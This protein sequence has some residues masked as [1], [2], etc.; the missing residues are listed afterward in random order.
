[1][2]G[3]KI[4]DTYLGSYNTI[5]KHP[6]NQIISLCSGRN[7]FVDD[8]FM[9]VKTLTAYVFE[10][11]NRAIW[12]SQGNPCRVP[13]Y[14]YAPF[15]GS[16]GPLDVKYPPDHGYQYLGEIAKFMVDLFRSSIPYKNKRTIQNGPPL[17]GNW[18]ITKDVSVRGETIDM[19]GDIVVKSGATLNLHN[20]RLIMHSFTVGLKF[21]SY[22]RIVVEKGAT[23]KSLQEYH[24]EI[25]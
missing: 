25:K 22:N 8:M 13:Y 16:L 14:R 20:V 3:I 23:I 7:A 11:M 2:C 5:C 21:G 18:I 6:T 15:D 4:G 24:S 10:P 12:I 17:I 1:M 9:P 19:H